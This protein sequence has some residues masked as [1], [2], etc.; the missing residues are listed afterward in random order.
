MMVSRSTRRFLTW[1]YIDIDS[2]IN[3]RHVNAQHSS[4]SSSS[5]CGC[6][7]FPSGEEKNKKKK[8]SVHSIRRNH[9][10][11]RL[12]VASP[13]WGSSKFI[14]VV[15]RSW[16]RQGKGQGTGEKGDGYTTRRH[17]REMTMERREKC[18]K[19]NKKWKVKK[20][21]KTEKKNLFL[22]FFNS[23]KR[24]CSHHWV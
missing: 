3:D 24:T 1:R 18:W 5:L 21:K 17:Y 9:K 8:K 12:P 7:S 22:G 15:H 19:N 14:Y 10:T 23:Y 2:I 20:N 6:H 13:R 16:I 11:S 4:S